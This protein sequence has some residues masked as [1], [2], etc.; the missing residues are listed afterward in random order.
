M[1]LC[2]WVDGAEEAERERQ[3]QRQKQRR[4]SRELQL[5]FLLSKSLTNRRQQDA[6]LPVPLVASDGGGNM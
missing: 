4:E 3:R 5:H 6:L 2:E 1:I